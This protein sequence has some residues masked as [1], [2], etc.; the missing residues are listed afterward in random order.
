MQTD[1]KLIFGGAFTNLS[2]QA[3]HHIG[4]LNVDGTADPSMDTGL[5]GDVYALAIQEDGKILAGGNFGR[6]RRADGVLGPTCLGVARFNS[7]G[8][9][10]LSFKGSA[11]SVTYLCLQ[12]DQRILVGGPGSLQRLE[13]D[14]RRDT[15]FNLVVRGSIT[16]LALQADGKIL[17]GGDFQGLAGLACTNLGRLNSD[18][19]LDDSFHPTLSRPP[20]CMA[21]QPDGAIL[22]GGLDTSLAAKI[23]RLNA[24][25]TEDTTFTPHSIQSG[26]VDPGSVRS[27]VLQADRALILGG[28]F[29]RISA[30]PGY[31]A[32]TNLARLS[33]HGV[34]D[35]EFHPKSM[36]PL[37]LLLQPDGALL[38][39][40]DFQYHI[41]RL[42]NAEPATQQLNCSGSEIQWL[43]GGT[44]P[45]I[46]RAVFEASTNGADWILL[47][48]A[49]PMLGGWQLSGTLL[50]PGTFVRA[51][52]FVTG[53]YL[54]G[55]SW[56][57][58]QTVVAPPSLAILTQDSRFGFIANQFGFAF[59]GL[60]G[61]LVIVEGSS[62]LS[63][64][65]PLA[66]NTLGADP[67]YFSEPASPSV[68]RRF[69]RL[70]W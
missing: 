61:Q 5:N 29:D 65:L 62:D 35:A 64:W 18:G 60:S 23:F 4:R 58:E 38:L 13:T 45:G 24:D 32:R 34:V 28:L 69:Y 12:K 51:R 49:S 39:A 3:R 2:G 7:N 44:S 42:T 50:P 36:A 68:P 16:C 57:V 33:H 53:G 11:G 15:N 67:S 66:T 21:V 41:A 55:S 59:T 14:G 63:N 25:G 26:P 9:P 37:G 46:W 10:D 48:D 40:G 56:F 70:R 43:R 27:I 19:I 1:G 20:D 17:V 31:Y 6:F 47:G 54:N 30:S 52:G 8:T 22:A